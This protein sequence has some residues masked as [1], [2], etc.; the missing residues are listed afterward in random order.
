[1]NNGKRAS[2]PPINYEL[3]P[4]LTMDNGHIVVS[5]IMSPD[6]N[7]RFV[8]SAL[9]VSQEL[10]LAFC[11]AFIKKTGPKGTWRAPDSLKAGFGSLKSFANYL[12]TLP[13]A[14]KNVGQLSRPHYAGWRSEMR[15]RH[16]NT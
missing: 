11:N 15:K 13:D 16:K 1:M 7:G 9:P 8:F 5:D 10:Q 6:A 14:P 3:P 12:A 2:Q 4:R